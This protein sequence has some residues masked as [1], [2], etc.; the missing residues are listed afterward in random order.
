MHKAVA[1]LQD[2]V[3]PAYARTGSVSQLLWEAVGFDEASSSGL[4]LG[5]CSLAGAVLSLKLFCAPSWSMF[6]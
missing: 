1:T 3:E 2:A 4:A 5:L 6:A